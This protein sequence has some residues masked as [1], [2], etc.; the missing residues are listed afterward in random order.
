MNILSLKFAQIKK[1][2]HMAYD[3]FLKNTENFELQN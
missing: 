2:I 1:Q 3:W